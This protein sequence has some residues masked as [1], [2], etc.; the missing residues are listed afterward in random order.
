VTQAEKAIRARGA[1]PI[2]LAVCPA[3]A[4]IAYP[5]KALPGAIAARNPDPD[6]KITR[7]LG[8]LILAEVTV[9]P[10]QIRPGKSARI[11]I[12]LRRNALRQFSVGSCR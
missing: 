6:N 11:H 12:V 10:G 2:A 7:D 4:E 3:G 1:E 8:G 5:M 9:V